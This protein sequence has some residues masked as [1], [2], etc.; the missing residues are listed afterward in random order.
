MQVS[1]NC[2]ISQISLDMKL[3]FCKWLN[4]HKGNK[5]ISDFMWA[6]S[7][8]P[9]DPKVTQIDESTW[10]YFLACV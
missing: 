4:I 2:C 9:G 10:N 3:N 1:L 5:I 6:F 7:G 8:K